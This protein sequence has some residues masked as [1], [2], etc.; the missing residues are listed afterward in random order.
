MMKRACLLATISLL[1]AC[2]SST[3][4]PAAGKPAAQPAISAVP[5]EGLPP[6]RLLPG[7]CGLFLWGMSA[8]RKF[9]FFLEG[10]SGEALILVDDVPT[11]MTMATAGG[12]V[13]GQ[14]LTEMR[15]GASANGPAISVS[16]TPGE[17]LEGG[18]RVDTG[19]LLIKSPEGWETILP[20]TG[21]RACMPG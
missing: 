20:I 3:E 18:Q 21:V 17:V 4:A 2:A 6:Q 5:S 12:E 9:V 8:P 15:F 7:Q 10:S 14:F 11:S 1:T 13:F 16:L 19:H